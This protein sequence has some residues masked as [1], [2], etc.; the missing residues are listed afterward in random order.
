MLILKGSASLSLCICP[1]IG[2]AAIYGNVLV[3]LGIYFQK[4]R[5]LANGLALAGASIGQFAI[6]PFIEFLLETYG[7]Q[8][9]LLLVSIAVRFSSTSRLAAV[10]FWDLLIMLLSLLVALTL[11]A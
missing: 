5:T 1:G 3:I 11:F 9:C 10:V 4:R 2:N 6:P 8:G 7:L